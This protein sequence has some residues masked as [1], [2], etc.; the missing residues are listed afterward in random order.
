MKKLIVKLGERSYPIFFGHGHP[1]KLKSL[2]RKHFP[3]SA[4]F[5]VTNTTV[6]KLYQSKFD[7]LFPESHVITV[8]DGEKYKTIETANFVFTQLVKNG[9]DRKSV[10]LAFGGGVVGDLAGFVAATYMRGVAFVQVPTTLLAMADGAVGGKTAVNHPL[11]KNSIG[12]F[13][14]PKFVFIDTAFLKTLPER[15]RVCGLAEIIKY[16]LTLDKN[17]FIWLET[18]FRKILL[19]EEE[20]IRRSVVRSCEL[21][22]GI[23]EQDE[24]ESHRRML[25]NFGHTWAHAFESLSGYTILK[26]GEAV[27]LGM[28]AAGHLSYRLK[29]ISYPEWIRIEQCISALLPGVLKRKNVIR[30]FRRLHWNNILTAMRSDKKAQNNRVRWVVLDSIG[31]AIIADGENQAAAQQSFEYLKQLISYGSKN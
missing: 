22:A 7:S 1:E 3:G 13:Y 24:K 19:L 25:L 14:Q 2:L 9:A 12:A 31:K 23:V 10:I 26:H 15:E 18:K 29:R 8:P 11:A 5:V 28:L 4:C 20:C 17:F 27:L 6:R 21:K 16:G 30:L